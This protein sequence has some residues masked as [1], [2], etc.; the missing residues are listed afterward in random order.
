LTATLL[1]CVLVIVAA[2]C[3]SDHNDKG[4]ES[5][6]T[7][8][9]ATTTPSSAGAPTQLGPNN[10]SIFAT[11]DVS[12]ALEQLTSAYKTAHP[13]VTFQVTTGTTDQLVSQVNQGTRPNL[14][15][16]EERALGRLSKSIVKGT[17]TLFG[18]DIPVVI[19][20]KGDPA[21]ADAGSFGPQPATTSG[22][23]AEDLTCGIYGRYYLGALKIAPVPDRV[24]SDESALVNGVADGDL[25]VA[26]VMRSASRNRFFKVALV[27]NWYAPKIEINYKIATITDSP[28]AQDFVNFVTTFDT[29]NQILVSRGFRSFYQLKKPAATAPTTT[30]ATKP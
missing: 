3:G 23:C 28:P 18:S 21:H 17:P 7:T 1:A 26:L 12:Q 11:G 20:K 16:D 10:I 8:P 14:Y 22:M 27:L 25:D 15:L 13:E 9:G 30:A 29:A 2:A 6:T 24:E 19:V 4:A 5:T